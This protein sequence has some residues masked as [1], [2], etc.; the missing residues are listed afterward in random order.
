MVEEE[1]R[2]PVNP[3]KLA[4]NSDKRNQVYRANLAQGKA[5]F[6]HREKPKKTHF[7]S[8]IKKRVIA[9]LKDDFNREQIIGYC[10]L[11]N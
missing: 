6:R 2:I 3:R 10:R 8:D 5:D 7:T 9:L 4:R 1:H 11:K